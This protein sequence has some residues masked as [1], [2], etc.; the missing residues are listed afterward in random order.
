MQTYLE[1]EQVGVFVGVMTV[2]SHKAAKRR[3]QIRD[4]WASHW[5]SRGRWATGGVLT[6]SELRAYEKNANILDPTARTV[7]RFVMGRPKPEWKERIQQEMKG[8]HQCFRRRPIV[9]NS[10]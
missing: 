6:Q 8:M 3:K 2:A 4:S 1:S 5:A 7:V 10:P 9:T